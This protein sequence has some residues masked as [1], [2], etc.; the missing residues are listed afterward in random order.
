MS[1]SLMDEVFPTDPTADQPTQSSVLATVV[2]EPICV[3]KEQSS[4]ATGKNGL[5]ALQHSIAS[6]SVFQHL[7]RHANQGVDDLT[8][9]R[10]ALI[11]GVPEEVQWA[12]KKYLA[13]SNKAAYLIRFRENPDLPPLLTQ[14]LTTL[15]PELSRLDLPVDDRKDLA[16][17]QRGLNAVLILR[18]MA[19]DPESSQ[20]LA[21]DAATKSFTLT[22]L[23]T[24]TSINNSTF[25]LYQNNAA[26]FNELI[27]YVV[28]IMEAISSYLAP[29]KK[30]DPYFKN[31]VSILGDTNDRYMVISIL[32]SLSRL[33]VRSKADDES[34]ADNL[35]DEVLNQI[36]SYLLVDCDS[37]LI[38][39][40]LD[41][42]YQY[43]LP[44]NE[45]ITI[46]LQNQ[47]RY[48][49]LTAV[50][51]KLLTYDVKMPDYAAFSNTKIRL[52]RR[53][54]PPAPTEPPGLDPQL[55]GQL[56]ALN[57]PMRSTAWLRCCFEPQPESEVT[58]IGLWRGYESQFSQAVKDSGRKL[59]PAV[60][61]IKNVSNAF[62]N[63]AAMVITDQG[64]G[65]KRFVIK[66]VQPRFRT[67]SIAEGEI[68]ATRTQEPAP[69]PSE[70]FQPQLKEATQISL[71]EIK[72]PTRLSDVSKA[73]ATFLCLVSNDVKGVGLTFCKQLRPIIIHKLADVPPL[74]PALSEYMDNVPFV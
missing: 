48:S 6:L 54:K 73:S 10:M 57:E 49:L 65:K 59:L 20:I 31:L 67:V 19:Q 51:P 22:V 39:A 11:S 2:P 43:V 35:H 62:K 72:F 66:G 36:C 58:Q 8:R 63:A 32:R 70:P 37:E 5:S 55:F 60:E 50:L 61:F 34:A 40:S 14:F 27:H 16:I 1:S 23:E 74:N 45:R 24:F 3:T 41:F 7:P 68:A 26:F 71:P 64:T 42:L 15:A 33:L 38:V 4:G 69:Q 13:Y 25:S 46:L 28:D 53:V 18:N 29:A 12:L 47:D 52:T 17:L 9:M 30:D 21:A 56:L 44:G